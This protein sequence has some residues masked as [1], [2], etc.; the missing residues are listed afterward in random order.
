MKFFLRFSE[1]FANEGREG[2]MRS[3]EEGRRQIK[4]EDNQIV[5]RGADEMK[6][7]PFA[8]KGSFPSSLAKNPIKIRRGRPSSSRYRLSVAPSDSLLAQLFR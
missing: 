5:F 4:N 1:R 2:R 8:T 6:I 3:G 7:Y